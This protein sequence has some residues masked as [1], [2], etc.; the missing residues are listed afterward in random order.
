M[1]YVKNNSF[2]TEMKIRLIFITVFY[3]YYFVSKKSCPFIFSKFK[4]KKDKT[5]WTPSNYFQR[6][7]VAT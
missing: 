6:R 2:G 7:A 3:Q 5:S 1:N 4:N